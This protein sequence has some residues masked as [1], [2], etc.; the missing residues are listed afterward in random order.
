MDQVN[1]RDLLT[2]EAP[3]NS[4]VLDSIA[5][6]FRK[7]G[8][9]V[10]AKQFGVKFVKAKQFG[11][12]FSKV[13]ESKIQQTTTVMYIAIHAPATDWRMW[14]GIGIALEIIIIIGMILFVIVTWVLWPPCM[15][16]AMKA[17]IY[18]RAAELASSWQQKEKW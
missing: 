14:I 11:V 1:A 16:L 15:L 6:H 9:F 12:T 13:P 8:F 17:S 10:K 2:K 5:R 7:C 3:G 4:I 18:K